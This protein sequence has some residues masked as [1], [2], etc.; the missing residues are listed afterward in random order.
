MAGYYTV[1]GY[2]VTLG[3]KGAWGGRGQGRLGGWGGRE[4]DKGMEMPGAKG[5][6][7]RKGAFAGGRKGPQ[8]GADSSD[9]EG[10]P[11]TTRAVW[12]STAHAC[13]ISDKKNDSSSPE[14]EPW[15]AQ[16][17]KLA[18]PVFIAESTKTSTLPLRVIRTSLWATLTVN[19][20]RVSMGLS[21]LPSPVRS[22]THAC[23]WS[24]WWFTSDPYC[25]HNPSI[26][27]SVVSGNCYGKWLY[28]LQP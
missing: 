27:T 15:P 16:R 3:R 22:S 4:P 19:P 21:R 11:A 24:W 10:G 9:S 23:D 6:L 25:K 13:T 12:Y 26:T 17:A 2:P 5:S 1:R 7:G 14:I 8:A 18:G 28:L 20:R